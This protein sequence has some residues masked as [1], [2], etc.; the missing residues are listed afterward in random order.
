MRGYGIPQAMWAVECHTDEV[1]A[2]IGMDPIAFRRKNLMP[3]GFKDEFS[4]MSCTP[5][6]LTSVWIRAWQPLITSASIKNT[7]TRPA[8]S[9]AVS[10][11]R[12]SGTTRQYG[13]SPWRPLPAAWY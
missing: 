11:C 13:Q 12:F 10:V 9:A 6:P 3:V 2:K 7:R 4:R 1:A 8:T 5:I